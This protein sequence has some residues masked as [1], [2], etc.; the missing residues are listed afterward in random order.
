MKKEIEN[1]WKKLKIWLGSST[2]MDSKTYNEYIHEA[3]LAYIGNE[4]GYAIVTPTDFSKLVL[5]TYETDL[6][7]KLQELFNEPITLEFL[8]KDEYELREQIL[9]KT[10]LNNEQFVEFSFKNFISGST[11]N[12]AFAAAKTVS[13]NLG[14]AWNPLFI[15]GSTGLGKTHLLKAIEHN[16]L[17][18][19]KYKLKIRYIDSE[20]FGNAVVEIIS[21]GHEA[22][23]KFI[24]QTFGSYDVLLIDDIQLIAKRQKTNEI[25]FKIFNYF[26]NNNKQL[27]LTSDKYP[28]ELDGFEERLISRFQSG[29]TVGIEAPDYETAMLIIKSDLENQGILQL[30][31]DEVKIYMAQNLSSDVRKI[32]GFIIKLQ[33]WNIQNNSEEH[34]ITLD[35]IFS[36]TKD[37]PISN[38]GKLNPRRIKEVVADTYG[39]NVKSME[40][41]SRIKPLII[42]RYV[43]MYLMKHLLNMTLDR[44]GSQF[45]GRDHSTV[46]TAITRIEEEIQ[47][48]ISFKKVVEKL[49]KQL[50]RP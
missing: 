9:N 43:A 42:P 33:F 48:S 12:N 2:I 21:S 16:A 23:E 1:I 27:V 50:S 13:E 40:S 25:F 8:T 19:S 34:I 30:I 46:V 10:T 38:I 6:H 11:N 44:I 17:I 20:T 32:K 39:V 36:L 29:L 37:A 18:N 45:S 35:D 22:I 24:N 3:K 7:K 31:S 26:I 4:N 28:E 49:K 14:K 47:K 41:Q 5:S 15:F